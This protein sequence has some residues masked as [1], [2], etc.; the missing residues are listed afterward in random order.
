MKPLSLKPISQYL[1]PITK[2][3]QYNKERCV[4][5]FLG[6]AMAYHNGQRFSAKDK[7]SDTSTFNCANVYQGGWW[8]RSCHMANMNGLYMKGK[9]TSHSV[10]ITWYQWKGFD[11]SLK[12]TT[13]MIRRE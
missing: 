11:Y 4:I 5:I 9:N 12:R 2:E 3:K 10:G 13:M 7:D 1:I 6:D 8:Y